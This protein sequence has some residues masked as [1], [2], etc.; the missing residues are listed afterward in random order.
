R[1]RPDQSLV[2]RGGRLREEKHAA[3]L[4]RRDPARPE[5]EGEVLA[6]RVREVAARVEA[7][8]GFSASEFRQVVMLPQEQFRKLISA[9]SADRQKVLQTLFRT[10]LYRRIEAALK[11]RAG[12]TH[13]AM[14]RLRDREAGL[15][16]S[17][18]IEGREH[19]QARLDAAVAAL[20]GARE[21]LEELRSAEAGRRAA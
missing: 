9:G 5:A 14:D 17:A 15:L 6:A 3:T 10:A 1:R 7:V 11:E 18:G 12:D 16:Q 2:G 21:R 8:L 20:A 13:K 19:L 4:W